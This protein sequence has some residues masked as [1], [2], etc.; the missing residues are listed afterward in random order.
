MKKQTRYIILLLLLL[1]AVGNG[2]AQETKISVKGNGQTLSDMLE[3]VSKQHHIRFAFDASYF[4]QLKVNDDFNNKDLSDFLDAVC[5]KFHLIAEDIDGTIVLYSKPQ[6]IMKSI[7]DRIEFGGIVLD[8]TTGEPLLYCNIAFNDSENSGTTTNELGI[9]TTKIKK[10][11][12]IEVSLSHLGYQRLDT[13]IHIN[14]QSLHTIRLSPFTIQM[15]A[16]KVTQQEKDVI[17]M[18]NQ[19]ERIAFNP[20]QSTNFPRVDDSD[21]ISSLHLI[22]GIDFIGGQTSGILIRGS[23]PSENLVTLDGIPILETSHLFGNLSVLNSKFVSQAFVSRGAFD[24]RYGEK[25]SG[26]IELKGKSDFYKPSLDLSANLM[27]V[28]ATANVPVNKKVSVVAA[29]RRSYIDRWENYLYRTILDQA[30][31]DNEASV[32]PIV[33]FDDLNL[34][35]DLRPSDKHEFSF[36]FINSTDF[37]E[38]NYEFKENSRLYHDEYADSNNNGLS[39]NWFFQVSKNFQQRLTAGYNELTRTSYNNAGM[40]ENSQGNGGK[41]ELDTDNNFLKEFSASWSAE[42]TSGRMT[43]QAGFG[44]NFDEVQYNYLTNKSTE[45]KVM[46]SVSFYSKTNILHAYLQEKIHLNEKLEV[47]VGVRSNYLDL[48]QKFYLQPRVG[49]TYSLNN[50]IKLIYA[51]GLY[52]QFLS[53]IRKIDIDNNSDLVW[54]LPTDDGEGVLKAWQNLIG[55]QYSYNGLTIN[56]EA[57]MKNTTGRV[58]FYAEQ[59]SSKGKLIEYYLRNGQSNNKGIDVMF[60]YRHARFTHILGSSI[61]RSEEQFDGFNENKYYPSFYDQ[62]LKIRWTELFKLKNWVFSSSFFYHSGTPYLTN[63]DLSTPINI[64]KLPYF[65]QADL[66]VT[67]RLRYKFCSFNLGFSL[68]NILDRKNILEVDYFNISDATGTYAVRTDITSIQFTPVFFLNVLLK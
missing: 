9:F 57:Y 65:L 60:Q 31:S 28:S 43:H 61:S 38:R 47:R 40:T 27:N 22:P 20:K 21:L 3:T 45:T 24:A 54:Y 13:L 48:T 12:Q 26:I 17:E 11:D 30:S 59:T 37:Q 19:T 44:A 63:N 34:K 64:E 10:K 16:I 6:T 56:A 35:V 49:L 41:D 29:F 8:K 53:R 39:A 15:E 46:D 18:G 2:F 1:L 42:L 14:Q 36:N 67:R 33:K 51:S 58:N 66:Y 62:R 7:H 55:F 50:K 25:I 32:S 52:N 4:S 5:N 23:A 68:M